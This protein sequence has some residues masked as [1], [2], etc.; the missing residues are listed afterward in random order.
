MKRKISSLVKTIR[1]DVIAII[2]FGSTVYM[3]RGRDLDVIVIVENYFKDPIN[4]SIELR[5]KLNKMLKYNPIVD[6][7][8]FTIEDFKSNLTPGSFLSGLALGYEII[9]DRSRGHIHELIMKMLE[10]LSRS[11]HILVN[12]YGE[13]SLHVHAKHLLRRRKGTM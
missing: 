11:E 1:S 5:T 2:L 10:E 12:R 13:W 7:H 6:V 9:Y 8:V 4:D 3:G